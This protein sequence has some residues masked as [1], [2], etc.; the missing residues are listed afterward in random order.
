M[1]ITHFKRQGSS[2]LIL[3][4]S[5]EKYYIVYDHIHGYLKLEELWNVPKIWKDKTY[6]ESHHKTILY[7]NYPKSNNGIENFIDIQNSINEVIDKN[8]QVEIENYIESYYVGSKLGDRDIINGIDITNNTVYQ[9]I[10]KCEINLIEFFKPWN[11][12]T[13]NKLMINSSTELL[14]KKFSDL[15]SAIHWYGIK[16]HEKDVEGFLKAV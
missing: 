9:V 1:I 14:N 2:L 6:Y 4:D 10:D 16:S 11:C 15:Y 5:S 12:E 8:C 3:Q 7:K 13:I